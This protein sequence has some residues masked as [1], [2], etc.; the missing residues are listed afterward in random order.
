LQGLRLPLKPDQYRDDTEA[1]WADIAGAF[2]GPAA[3]EKHARELYK[4][5]YQI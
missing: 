2:V 3:P 5:T 4:K 1:A